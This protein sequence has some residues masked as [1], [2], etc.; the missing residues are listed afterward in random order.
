MAKAST[1][2]L[3]G[4][5]SARGSVSWTPALI[6]SAELSADAGNFRLSAELWET[7]LGADDRIR[8][9]VD[10]RTDTLL[11]LPLCFEQSGDGRKSGVVVNSLE[12]ARGDWWF[13]FPTSEQKLIHSWVVGLNIGLGQIVWHK[14]NGRDVPRLHAKSP[15]HLRWD[16]P[17]RKWMLTVADGVGTKEI[18]I[19]PGNGEWVLF[20][21][22]GESRPWIHGA[23]R[24]LSRWTLL[25]QYGL[26]DLGYYS[27]R[28]GQGILVAEA[29]AMAGQQTVAT[30]AASKKGVREAIAADLQQLGAN[31][32]L[33]LPPGYK[34]R[35]VEAQARTWEAFVAQIKLAD[36]GAAVTVLGQN[37]TTEVSSGTNA[38]TSEHGKVA[39]GRVKFDNEWQSTGYRT[40]VLEFYSEFN[41]GDPELAPWPMRD[42]CLPEDE[43]AKAT[44]RQLDAQADATLVGSG[45]ET[46]NEARARR[47]LPPK[48]GGDELRTKDAAAAAAPVA[49]PEGDEPPAP[50]SPAPAPTPPATEPDDDENAPAPPANGDT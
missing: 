31:S 7:M 34:L 35:L 42:T 19:V 36:N 6:R 17:T 44:V 37:L 22:S 32:A 11:G 26:Q 29:E 43:K 48:D 40:Q 46:P 33:A 16:W 38:A 5:P 8:A 14:R 47:G 21:P 10:T 27:E 9:V 20:T 24:A 15:R 23:Y 18:E 12:G 50:T 45:I 39:L 28:H 13:A 2:T 4:E 1:L 41:W 49:E 3:Q 30:G 25:K